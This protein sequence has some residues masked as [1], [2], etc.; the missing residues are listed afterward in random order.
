MYHIQPASTE[1]VFAPCHPYGATTLSALGFKLRLRLWIAKA[2][3][4]S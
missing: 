1:A 2:A 3:Y 4:L